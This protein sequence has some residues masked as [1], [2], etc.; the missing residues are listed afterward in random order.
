MW[1]ATTDFSGQPDAWDYFQNQIL[2]RAERDGN[3]DGKVDL[4]VFYHDAVRQKL[5]QDRDFDGRFEITQW[6]DRPP[7][8]M[9]MEL[10]MDLNGTPEGR[11]CYQDGVL[12]EKMVDEDADG[13]F[14]LREI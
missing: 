8:S 2:V 12:R 4:K 5:I 6:F 14:D 3:G 10:D 11:Y 7:W 9:V 13:R 1:S